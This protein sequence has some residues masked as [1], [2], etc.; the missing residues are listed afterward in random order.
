MTDTTMPAAR[1]IM[2]RI[3]ALAAHSDEPGRL[4]RLGFGS[5]MQR[6][7]SQVAAWM[8]A[9]GLEVTRDALGNVVGHYAAAHAGATPP[10]VLLLGSHL[11]TVRDAGTYDGTLGILVALACVEQLAQRGERLPF[12]LE[13]AAFAEEE[14]VRFPVSYVGSRALAGS[15][16]APMLARVDAE[17]ISLAE[18]IQAAGGD[19][20][21]LPQVRRDPHTLLAY[22]EVHIEQGP[23]L[24]SRGL[25]VGVVT[26]IAGQSRASITLTGTAGHAGTV[27]MLLRA[28][29]LAAAAQ[30]IT[31]IETVARGVPELVA[32]VGEISAHPGMSNV[33]PGRV[34][35][36]LDV[37]HQQDSQRVAA[38]AQMQAQARAICEER[39]IGL[40]WQ[41]THE[42]AATPCAPAW[43]DML[44]ESIAA[45]GHPVQRLPSGGGHDG[46]ALAAITDVA[47]LFVRCQEGISHHPAE[48]VREEDIA[49]AVAVLTGL[50]E[51]AA[52]RYV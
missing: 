30:V 37:R 39:G 33:I 15:L 24:D 42:H 28:D 18:A 48:A 50:L 29:A 27:P 22:C 26:A 34:R 11:D 41:P 6:A 38:V 31:V 52:A 16:D 45:T 4:T 9:A 32:T 49:V 10:R 46:V 19:P 25:P 14:G 36:S 5:A 51:R 43:C 12:A 2:Q 13:V 23:V 47:M 3:G 8:R 7:S 44:A 21:A 40:D 1:Q 20:A 17:G 35:F